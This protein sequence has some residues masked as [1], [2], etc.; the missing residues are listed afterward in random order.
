LATESV[1]HA[2]P[3]Q[4]APESVHVTPLFCASLPTVAVKLFAWPV[5]SDADGGATA[6]VTAGV[7]VMVALATLLP[8]DAEVAVRVTVAGDGAETGAV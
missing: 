5:C 6:T 1:P 8:S 7:T 3:L 4:P 2:A